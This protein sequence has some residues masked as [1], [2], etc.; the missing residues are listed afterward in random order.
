MQRKQTKIIATISDRRCDLEFIES[1]YKAGMNVVRLNTAHQTPA[2]T[3]KVVENVRKVSD[4]IALLLDTKGPEIRTT[5]V[6]EDIVLNDKD[7]IRI[8]RD[9]E[10]TDAFGVSF[11]GLIDELTPGRE[12]LIDDGATKLRVIEKKSDE[13]ICE[14]VD[15]G[16]IGNKKSLNVPGVH[17]SLPSLT[18][19]DREYIEFAVE[20]EI[21]FIAHSFVRNRDDVM[22]VQSILDTHNSPVKII[23][24]IENQEGINNIDEILDCVYGIMI[25]RGDLGI[26]IPAAEV[27]LVQK[28]MIDKCIIRARPVI[29]ATQMLHSMIDNPRPTRAEVSDI[30]NAVLDGTDAL[31]LSGETAYGKY[32]L[33]SV[34]AMYDIACRIEASKEELK[35]HQFYSNEQGHIVSNYLAKTAVHS[36]RDLKAKAILSDTMTGYSARYVSSYRSKVPVCART[37]DKRVVRELALSYGIIPFYTERSEDTDTLVR[38]S[39][40]QLITL[41]VVTETDLVLILASSP[42]RTSGANL[43]ELNTPINCMKHKI[44]M[45]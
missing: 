32:P 9:G 39:M 19:K 31:M 15:G 33:E 43:I 20:H 21:D 12:I 24:K 5:S 7:I 41:G 1:L 6:T 10:G 36:A 28:M 38:Q 4:E 40:S 29:T 22:A 37:H 44:N 26:E 30:A 14:S 3:L 35:D 25:A 45:K 27:P 8:T 18:A 2:D 16:V 23:A 11:S 34:K 17:L 42:E 13:L